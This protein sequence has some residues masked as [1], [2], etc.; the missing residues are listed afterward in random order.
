M[1]KLIAQWWIAMLTP[2]L[3]WALVAP[4]VASAGR[5][6]QARHECPHIR[7]THGVGSDLRTYRKPRDLCSQN[8]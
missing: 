2:W 5:Y 7:V 6:E 1:T 3:V 4:I 8:R